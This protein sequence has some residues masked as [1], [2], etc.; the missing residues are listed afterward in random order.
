MPRLLRTALPP[1]L[2]HVTSRGNNREPLFRT[3]RDHLVFYRI[4]HETTRDLHV[5]VLAHCLMPNHFHLLLETGISQLSRCMQRVKSRYAVYVNTVHGRSGHVFEKR[6]HAVPVLCQQ[7]LVAVTR[8]IARN[9]VAA[10]LCAHPEDWEWG[11][12]RL[13]SAQE[14]PPPWLATGRLRALL[15][16]EPSS[17]WRE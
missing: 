17:L 1:G 2:H 8:Y 15:G 16:L 9:P 10:G 12:A 11:S 4:L 14:T 3:P 7:Q 5:H 6:F 13:A